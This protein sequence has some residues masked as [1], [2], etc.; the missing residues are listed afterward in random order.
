VE[1]LG[2]GVMVPRVDAKKPIVQ[3]RSIEGPVRGEPVRHRLPFP[4]G[5]ASPFEKADDFGGET[6]GLA[7]GKLIPEAAVGQTAAQ[8]TRKRDAV[9]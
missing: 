2:K 5:A 1:E 3:G 7:E 4:E 8:T 6:G 9:I